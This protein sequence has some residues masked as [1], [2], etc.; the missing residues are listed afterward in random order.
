MIRNYD[1][2]RAVLL[3]TV[4]LLSVV[5]GVVPFSKTGKAAVTSFVIAS[6]DT[7]IAPGNSFNYFGFHETSSDYLYV[8]IDEDGNGAYT[9]GEQYMNISVGTASFDGTF[10]EEKTVGLDGTY[11]VYAID[12]TTFSDG[13]LD[14]GDDLTNGSSA[15]VHR[16]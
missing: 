9:A 2:T 6:E 13:T 3:A 11:R 8:V 1:R 7:E 12:G 10:Q 15:P 16:G 14:A 4:L 5:L